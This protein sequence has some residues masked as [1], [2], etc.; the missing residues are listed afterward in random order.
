MKILQ[1]REAGHRLVFQDKGNR[2]AR[3]F[4]GWEL[5]PKKKKKR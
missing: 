2:L 3:V 4:T 5:K 1:V